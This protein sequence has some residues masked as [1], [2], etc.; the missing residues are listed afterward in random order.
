MASDISKKIRA[1]LSPVSFLVTKLNSC[2]TVGAI[3]PV[4]VSFAIISLSLSD[5]VAEFQILRPPRGTPR[6]WCT[7][8]AFSSKLEPF[9]NLTVLVATSKLFASK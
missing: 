7:T 6:I 9:C 1:N 8:K 5:F 3:V 4:P 2:S